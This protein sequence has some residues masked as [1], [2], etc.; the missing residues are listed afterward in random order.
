MRIDPLPVLPRKGSFAAAS[1]SRSPSSG[2]FGFP[3]AGRALTM[4]HLLFWPVKPV[5]VFLWCSRAEFRV[6]ILV[7]TQN[8][9]SSSL[10]P[11]TP[12]QGSGRATWFRSH[13]AV[14]PL[15]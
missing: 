14:G 8:V 1:S 11:P 7:Y 5:V 15:T 10:S 9:G 2:F 13:V 12:H 4:T 3:F 6:R